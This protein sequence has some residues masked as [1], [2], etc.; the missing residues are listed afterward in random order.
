MSR[1]KYSYKTIGGVK[2]RIHRHIVEEYI[3]RPL[4]EN[5]HVYHINGNP[6]DNRLDNLQ[7]IVKKLKDNHE[8]FKSSNHP[9]EH[10]HMV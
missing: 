7:I 5:E 9:D 2:K 4:K 8:Q 10:S 3:G 1:N 6:D